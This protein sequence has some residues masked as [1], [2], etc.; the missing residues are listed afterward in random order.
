M[1]ALHFSLVIS[2]FLC[3]ACHDRFPLQPKDA[4]AGTFTLTAHASQIRSYPNGGGIFTV[5]LV[6]EDGFKGSVRLSVRADADLRCTLS[7]PRLDSVNRVV[8]LRLAP[9]ANATVEP[10]QI[11]LRAWHGGSMTSLPLTV[12]MYDWSYAE[13]GEETMLL[14]RYLAWVHANHRELGRVD[15]SGFQRYLTYPYHLIVEHWSFVNV[16]WEVRLCRHVMVPPGDWSM[17]LLRRLGTREPVLAARLDQ[18]MSEIREIPVSEYPILYG[19]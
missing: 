15:V 6:P 13:P 11:E 10:K 8:E 14:D 3:A 4:D 18:T 5:S 12:D 16:L 2:L 9:T 19:Y 17:I 7:L 1:K